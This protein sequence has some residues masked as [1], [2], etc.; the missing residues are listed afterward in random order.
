MKEQ[1]FKCNDILGK[2]EILKFIKKSPMGEVY[3]AKT[4]KNNKKY[5]LKILS[6]ELL[7]NKSFISKFKIDARVMADLVHENIVR[8]NHLEQDDKYLYVAMDFIDNAQTLKEYIRTNEEKSEEKILN[9][10]YQISSALDYAYYHKNKELL[11]KDL[12]PSNILIDSDGCIKI[13]DF[14]LSETISEQNKD[15]IKSVRHRNLHT[16]QNSFTE[17]SNMSNF[18]YIAPEIL[19]GESF[20]RQSDIYA[21]G[22]IL[23]E[24]LTKKC[25][26]GDWK[27]P[28]EYGRTKDWDSII[29]KC[30]AK[31]PEERYEDASSIYHSF[32]H[33]EKKKVFLGSF[34]YILV[35]SIFLF[36]FGTWAIV[37][38]F[39]QDPKVLNANSKNKKQIQLEN[40]FAMKPISKIMSPLSS[41]KKQKKVI[42]PKLGKDWKIPELGIKFK[43]IS[44]GTFMMGGSK[45]SEKNQLPARKV[46]ISQ[47]F[48]MSVYEITEK[49]YKA[50]NE[51][52]FF[53]YKPKRNISWEQAMDFC[54]KLTEQ[55]KNENRIP[56]GFVY[57]LPTEAEWEF[58]A[59]TILSP[60]TNMHYEYSGGNILDTLAWNRDNSN[61]N[62]QNVGMKKANKKGLYDMTGNALEWCYDSYDAE[63]YKDSKSTNPVCLE[64]S[65]YKVLRGGHWNSKKE[66]LQ[67]T[68]RFYKKK[69]EKTEH[70]G[71]R[72]VLAKGIN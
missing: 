7:N 28:S 72:V 52:K 43:A 29:L 17:I 37:N 58:C 71:F 20:K 25:P 70:I 18:N 51:D 33:K 13:T 15:L 59:K 50:L 4:S 9:L 63:F 56:N 40:S 2:Y 35:V 57:R 69:S 54:N 53:N 27:L 68:K 61:N 62:I 41:E 42:Q 48:W 5:A 66:D 22:V 31:N 34:F 12:I 14:G 47:D 32:F 49:E 16:S 30:L 23:Y 21:L 45:D 26:T 11:H 24:L 44:K 46:K 36:I 55:E 38:I 39:T 6:P 65:E 10:L 3:I 8:V 64:D 67:V 1:L 19:D 60:N